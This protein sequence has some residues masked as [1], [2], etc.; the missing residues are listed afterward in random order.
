MRFNGHFWLNQQQQRCSPQFESILDDHLSHHLLPAP[1]LLR[2]K[3][4]T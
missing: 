2:I 4:T 3:F 1:F